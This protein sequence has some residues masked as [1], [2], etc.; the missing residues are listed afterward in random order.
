MAPSRGPLAA[1]PYRL[2]AEGSSRVS[3]PGARRR[4]GPHGEAIE[5]EGGAAH[6][7]AERDQDHPE[8][9]GERQV[10]LAGLERDR[11]RHGAGEARDIAADDEDRADFGDGATERG[12]ES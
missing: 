4:S 2:S 9:E 7:K 10:S 11:G 12:Q 1:G 8:A 5:R 3:G 6:Q